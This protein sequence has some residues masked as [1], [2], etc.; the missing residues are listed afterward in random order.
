MSVQGSLPS[1]LPTR[2]RAD[3]LGIGKPVVARVVA[4]ELAANAGTGPVDVLT[5]ERNGSTYRVAAEDAEAYQ[6]HGGQH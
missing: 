4:D 6:P 2:V 3:V 1:Q 5:V